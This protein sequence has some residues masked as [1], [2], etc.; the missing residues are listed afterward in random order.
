MNTAMA[1]M[2][3]GN[4]DLIGGMRRNNRGARAARTLVQFL[5]VVCQMTT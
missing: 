1:T 4:N 5:D 2:T 3:S